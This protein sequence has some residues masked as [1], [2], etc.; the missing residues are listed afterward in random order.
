MVAL[1]VVSVVGVLLAPLIVE[2]FTLRVEGSDKAAQQEV[3]TTL[4]RLFMPQM[5]FYGF[6]ALATAVLHAHRR[7]AAAA[8]AP[9]LNNIV[10][11]AIFV[12]LPRLVDGPITL[13]R[14]R[15][16]NA[17]LL[18]LGLGTTAGIVA[19]ALVLVPAL[20]LAGVHLHR[21]LRLAPPRRHHDGAPVGVDRRIRDREPDRALDRPRAR[22]WLR[23]RALRVPEPRTRSSS[24]RTACSRCHS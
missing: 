24:S 9:I 23:R 12:S 22:Q 7:F 2:L 19:V 11:I 15:G 5:L 1:V 20:V 6:I 13:E 3:A 14:V 16:D 8:F 18:T 10:V 17:L 21:A 4:V